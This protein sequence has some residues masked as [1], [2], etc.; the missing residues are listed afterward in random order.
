MDQTV[1]KLKKRIEEIR[2]RAETPVVRIDEFQAWEDERT[3]EI[4]SLPPTNDGFTMHVG[5]FWSSLD[6][7]LWLK[8]ITRVPDLEDGYKIIGYFDFDSIHEGYASG[9]ESMLYVNGKPY[10]GVDENHKIVILDAFAGQKVELTFQ[11][12]AGITGGPKSRIYHQIKE[13]WLGRLGTEVEEFGLLA[14]MTLEQAQVLP[15]EDSR[16]MILFK[17]LDQSLSLI[18]WNGGED[19]WNSS[20]GEAKKSLE[21]ELA[22]YPER[23]PFTVH[24]AGHTHIDLAWMWRIKHTKEKAMRSF[25]TVLRLFEEFG[26]FLFYQSTPQIYQ[27]MKETA[28]QLYEQIKERIREGRWEVGGGMWVE[29]DCNLPGGESLVRQILY[30]KK[31]FME[32]FGV[33]TH[34]V[35]LPDAFGF[36]FCLPQILKKSGIDTFMTSKLSWNKQNRYPHDT[37]RWR[38]MDGSEVMAY[39]LT[40][41]A[42]GFP[43]QEWAVT[44]NGDI[45]PKVLQGTYELYQEKKWN[46]E[47]MVTYGHGDGGGGCTREMI[48]KISAMQ[49]VPFAPEVTYCHPG[50]FFH[51]L[52]EKAEAEKGLPVW[53]DELY[54]EYHRGTYTSQAFV[55][56]ENRRLESRFRNLEYLQVLDC[57]SRKKSYQEMEDLEPFWKVLLKNQ[58]HDILPGSSIHEVYEDARKD[59]EWLER[60]L[61][62]VEADIL[63]AVEYQDNYTVLNTGNWKRSC[64][65]EVP[66]GQ[67]S[68]RWR[69]SQ[70]LGIQSAMT[71]E[72]TEL[73]WIPE[74][75]PFGVC[76]LTRDWAEELSIEPPQ[77]ES[78][79]LARVDL[80]QSQVETSDYFLRWDENGQLVRLYD[81]KL[82]FEVFKKEPGNQLLVYEDKPLMFDAWDIDSYYREKSYPVALWDVREVE[83][84]TLRTI[85]RFRYKFGQSVLEQDM[86][87]RR[88]EQQI[89]FV[90]RVDW[91]ERQCLLKAHFPIHVRTREAVFD[92]Q[93]GNIKRSTTRNTSVEEARFE[94]CAH[95]F[96]DLSQ[97]DRG[98]S[99]LNDC[100]YGHDVLDNTIGLTLIKSS[101]DPDE[102]ADLGDHNFTY[103]ICP[104]SGSW[105]DGRIQEKAFALNTPCLI[106]KGILPEYTEPLFQIQGKYVEVDAIKPADDGNGLILRFH[107][108]AGGDCPVV[109]CS[110]YGIR[111][112]QECDLMEEKLSDPVRENVLKTVVEPYEIKTYRIWMED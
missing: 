24:C 21:Q 110:P 53:E 69:T 80:E 109:I 102:K 111:S 72:G 90:T 105:L 20:M 5:D 47:V 30:G 96:V 67:G 81:K 35:W 6:G 79:V 18:H 26:D 103:S 71:A 77:Y 108:Y 63:G 41:P 93:F 17:A 12:W 46:Q 25:S 38:G 59:Y 83:N 58:F 33:D 40:T 74:I 9:F 7:Y 62:R 42:F 55:K 107:E 91:K 37:F 45:T 16:M 14:Q 97:R 27:Y 84:S 94:V 49:K 78:G 54:L 85:L 100:K 98:V 92:T 8:V 88:G 34:F 61:T 82:A 104:H 86:V 52:E 48:Q 66:A 70:G 29:A 43:E 76:C 36:P 31:F 23:A 19:V 10:Q 87:L 60:E 32:E 2:A 106:H 73:L 64:F 68:A 39:F 50:P 13:A 44:Y 101:V 57:T 15:K 1:E 75:E 3:E 112:Y 89:D 11:L 28:P 51:S 65:L 22:K 99:I 95:R 4:N 56:R